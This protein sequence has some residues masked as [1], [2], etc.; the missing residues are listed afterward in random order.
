M[1]EIEDA[2]SAQRHNR[3]RKES[4]EQHD[5]GKEVKYG[6]KFQGT[7]HFCKEKGHF[8]RNCPKQRDGNPRGG[9]PRD[10]KG[11]ACRAQEENEQN[12]SNEEALFT[13]NAGD[14]CGWIIDSGATQHM[15][16]ERNRLSNYVEFKKPCSVN[17]GDN[18]SILAYGKGTYHVKAAVDDHTQNI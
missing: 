16:F 4:K 14:R 18:R 2:Y 9:N 8:A 3:R 13:S 17:L 1:F 11:T 6:G 10:G 7:C 12:H 15:T 5:K